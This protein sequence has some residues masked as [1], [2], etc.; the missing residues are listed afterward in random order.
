MMMMHDPFRV[1]WKV[2]Q[3]SFF[4]KQIFV[5]S[6]DTSGGDDDDDDD[7]LMISNDDDDLMISNDDDYLMISDDG[8]DDD[9]DDYTSGGMPDISPAPIT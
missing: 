8:D 4:S 5:C 1:G 7:D 2:D 3:F 9:D 6:G